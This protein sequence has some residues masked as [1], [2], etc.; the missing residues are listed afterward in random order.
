M[1]L[2]TILYHGTS[3]GYLDQ[4]LRDGLLPP[5]P[6]LRPEPGSYTCWTDTFSVAEFHAHH[7]E[8][9]DTEFL[10]K[11][12]DPIV[13]AVPIERFKVFGFVLEQ[14]FI[15]LGVSGEGGRNSDVELRGKQWNWR[16]LLKFTGGVGYE[17]P[18]PVSADM[19]IRL[20][21][22]SYDLDEVA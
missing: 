9:N 7:M 22:K 17:L 13:F 5:H 16:K 8:E 19:I 21:R 1:K 20:P 2:P 6:D 12:C 14:N 4:I 18:M 11:V 15:R 3:T 10:D